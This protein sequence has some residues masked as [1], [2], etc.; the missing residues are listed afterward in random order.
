MTLREQLERLPGG[1][2][3]I[4]S[5][6]LRRGVIKT[7]HESLEYSKLTQSD[8]AKKL[9]KSRSAVGQVFNGDGNVEI[10]TV[11]DY[12]FEMGVELQ[13]SI[14]PL[15]SNYRSVFQGWENTSLVPMEMSSLETTFAVNA[16]VMPI[17]SFKVENTG[18][19][20]SAQSTESHRASA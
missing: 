20:K 9:G 12:M 15:D 1:K 6:R 16:K 11:S 18:T 4:A 8:L 3:R 17:R 14:I 10:D 2:K 7:L 13:L 19:Q 5:A